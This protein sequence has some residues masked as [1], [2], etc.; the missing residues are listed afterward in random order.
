LP[1]A[2]H[3]KGLSPYWNSPTG[4]AISENSCETGPSLNTVNYDLETFEWGVMRI[5][6]VIPSNSYGGSR[7]QIAETIWQRQQ[8]KENF[9]LNTH[10]LL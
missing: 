1:N 3:L 6:R 9:P 8:M 5:L 10:I 7:E 4:V 2:V